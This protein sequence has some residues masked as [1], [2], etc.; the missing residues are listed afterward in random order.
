LFRRRGEDVLVEIPLTFAEMALGADIS[1]PTLEGVT[2]IRIPPG[3]APGR[4]FRLSGRGLPAVGRSARGDLHL[5]AVMTVPS[6]LTSAQREALAT[7]ADSL[8]DAS[9]PQR[10]SFD[11]HVQERR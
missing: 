9:H 5:E 10:Q 6:E 7:W 3:T 2:T 8:S 1:V 4:V 11:R